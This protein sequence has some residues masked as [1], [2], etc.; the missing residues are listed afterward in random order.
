VDEGQTPS[1]WRTAATIAAVYGAWFVIC[2]VGIGVMVVWH[3]ALLRAYIALRWDKWGMAL[4]NDTIVF[5]LVLAWL[6]FVI[7]IETLQDHA[8]AVVELDNRGQCFLEMLQPVPVKDDGFCRQSC[9]FSAF[10][11]LTA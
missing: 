5:V 10:N 2:A 11:Q 1:G 8:G 7:A 6:V 4:F 9:A 3:S